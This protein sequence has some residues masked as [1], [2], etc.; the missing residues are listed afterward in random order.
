MA[1][2]AQG[3]LPAGAFSLAGQAAVVTGASSGLGRMMARGLAQAGCA[4]LV[5]ARREEELAEV[6]AEI[7]AS[8]GGPRPGAP[9]CATPATPRTW[10]PPPGAPSGASTG[11]C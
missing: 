7:A 6:A 3:P 5:A 10:W 1:A 9:T 2:P 8:E 4:V 11:S